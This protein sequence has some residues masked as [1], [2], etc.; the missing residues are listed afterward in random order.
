MCPV[1]AFNR[2]LNAE[3]NAD[4][5][6][7]LGVEQKLPLSSSSYPTQHLVAFFRLRC[8]VVLSSIC[9]ATAAAV[10]TRVG[11]LQHLLRCTKYGL[12]RALIAIKE[13]ILHLHGCRSLA[14]LSRHEPTIDTCSRTTK[15]VEFIS[16]RSGIE[17]YTT[18]LLLT[19]MSVTV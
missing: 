5:S 6:G 18:T 19:R 12:C 13:S 14:S 3:K 8:C 2:V 7:L 9:S 4:L 11:F 16:G 10:V 17:E 15:R 1:K